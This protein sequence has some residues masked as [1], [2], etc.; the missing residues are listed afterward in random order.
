MAYLWPVCGPYRPCQTGPGGKHP[1]LSRRGSCFLLAPPRAGGP[2]LR[3]AAVLRIGLRVATS[4]IARKLTVENDCMAGDLPCN[5]TFAEDAPPW[6]A[7]LSGR[8]WPGSA[9]CI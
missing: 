4:V 2:P 3:V 7:M 6:T 5:L 1:H 9:G 8:S